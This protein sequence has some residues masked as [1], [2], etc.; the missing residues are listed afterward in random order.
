MKIANLIMGLLTSAFLFAGDIMPLFLGTISS[1]ISAVFYESAELDLDMANY[2]FTSFGCSILIC[3][4]AIA[5]IVLSI[6]GFIK[7][8]SKKAY[9]IIHSIICALLAGGF[10]AAIP[11]SGFADSIMHTGNNYYVWPVIGFIMVF[12]MIV[13]T[14][15]NGIIRR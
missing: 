15:I 6:V 9:T 7:K 14:V 2:A 8:K 4:L 10:A 13:L 12:I 11:V 5:G 1:F 3:I